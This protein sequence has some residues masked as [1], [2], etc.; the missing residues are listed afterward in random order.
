MDQEILNKFEEKGLLCP[1]VILRSGETSVSQ[2]GEPLKKEISQIATVVFETIGTIGDIKIDSIE[3][4][5]DKKGIII[6]LEDERLVGG[7]FDRTKDLALENFRKLV[8][9][10]KTQPSAVV[11]APIEITEIEKAALQPEILEKIKAISIEY[12]GDFTERIFQNQVKKQ[13]IKLEEFYDEDVR[14]LISGLSKA[15]GMIIGPSKASK[16]TNRLLKLLE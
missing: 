2:K 1:F 9:E 4:L 7:F 3:I 6:E 5:G 14:R 16:M 11:T 13:N 12:L 10:L 15:A 8:S